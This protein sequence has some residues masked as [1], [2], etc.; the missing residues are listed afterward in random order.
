MV[1]ERDFAVVSIPFAAG[2]S[3]A[4]AAAPASPAV[5][6]AAGAATLLAAQVVCISRRHATLQIALM[7]MLAGMLCALIE[8]HTFLGPGEGPI[9]AL[10]ARSCQALKRLIAGIGFPRPQ[11][12]AMLTALLSG[13]RSGLSPDTVALFRASGASHILALSG[14]HLGVIYVIL[15]KCLSILGNSPAA[16]RIRYILIIAASAFYTL[17]AGAGASLT[18]AFLFILLGETASITGRRRSP[19]RILLSALTI[20]LAVSPESI[21]SVG[22]QL[23][24]LAMCG[25]IFL[26]PRLSAVYNQTG[27]MK[28]LW[29]IITLSISCQAFTAPLSWYYFHSFPKYFILT[30][31]LVMPL[32]SAT[33]AVS[34]P[35]IILSAAGV[36]PDLLVE[37]TDKLTGVMISVLDIISRM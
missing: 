37:L 30:N 12:G 7:F 5:A 16:R 14:L 29:D 22:L 15:R 26:Q 35:T 18:R 8:M 32:S 2:I 3:A 36:C 21:K 6:G 10:A 31:I 13:D 33:M 1:G 24:Y 28:K 20:Q 4:V 23:S 9:S 17:M 34:I 11:T 27:P 25:I 19:V